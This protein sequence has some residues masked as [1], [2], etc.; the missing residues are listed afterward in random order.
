LSFLASSSQVV[1]GRVER[2]STLDDLTMAARETVVQVRALH[3]QGVGVELI[4]EIISDLNQRLF[5]RLFSFG[6]A[7]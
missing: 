4:G 5:S 6:G 1:T 7:G 3:R 2:A